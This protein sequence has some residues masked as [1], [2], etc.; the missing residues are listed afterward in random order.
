MNFM[1]VIELSHLTSCINFLQTG[2]ISFDKV[3]LNIMSCLPWG[4]LRNISWTS[5]RIFN[6]SN[7]LSHSSSTKCFKYLRLSYL[8]LIRANIRPGV[9]TTMYGHVLLKTSSSFWIGKPPKSTDTLTC[10]MCL[11]NLSYSLLIWNANS[12]VWHMTRT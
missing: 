3:A 1:I 8:V 6:C 9:P 12:L 2:Q 10:G 7:I 5:L 4:V 11:L